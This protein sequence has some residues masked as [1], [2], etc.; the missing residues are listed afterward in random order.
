MA[1]YE[2]KNPVRFIMELN[3]GL[4]TLLAWYRKFARGLMTIAKTCTAI[5]DAYLKSVASKLVF[6]NG[7]EVQNT[8]ENVPSFHNLKGTNPKE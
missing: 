6:R 8:T 4:R 3:R 5:E 7:P 2:V 1:C